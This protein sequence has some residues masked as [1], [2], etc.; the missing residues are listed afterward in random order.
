M[1][2][3]PAVWAVVVTYHPDPVLLG[4]LLAA[5]S[6]Q[7]TRIVVVD[8]GSSNRDAL[9]AVC[10][11]LGTVALVPLDDNTGIARAQNVGLLHA[12][13]AGAAQVVLFDQDSVPE[14]DLVSCLQSALATLTARG[15]RVGA[16]GANYAAGRHTPFRR[17]RGP[18]IRRCACEM[19]GQM[20]RVDFLIASGCLIPAEVLGAVGTMRE[21]L[22]IDYVDIEWSLRARAAGFELFGACDARMQHRPGDSTLSIAGRPVSLHSPLRRYYMFRNALWLYRQGW[23]PWRW[24]LADGI[25]LVA[26]FILYAVAGPARWQQLQSMLGG[27][28]DG[29]GNRLGR[30]A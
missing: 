13:G 25:N 20:P 14:A 18:F 24:K 7:V 27:L 3:A 29:L 8:N 16:V 5:L 19:P 17:V 6:P 30:R 2:S 15:A 12:L 23:V 22:F 11:R 1:T 10:Q 28:A 26:R 4:R 9:A 21:E